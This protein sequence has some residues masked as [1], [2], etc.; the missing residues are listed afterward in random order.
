[1]A[2]NKTAETEKSVSAFIK[3]VK[4]ATMREDSLQVIDIMAKQTGF[5]A[6]MW[7]PSIV[8]FGSYHY[9]YES[10]REGDAPLIGFSPRASAMVFYLSGNFDKRDELLQ[11]LGKHKTDKGCVYIKKLADIDIAVLK[12]MITA[13]F[14][15]KKSLYPDKPKK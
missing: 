8:G 12:K 15:H 2:K 14:K 7:G 10:G 13:S 11:S 6:K 1:M 5:E 9:I 3:T 4:D